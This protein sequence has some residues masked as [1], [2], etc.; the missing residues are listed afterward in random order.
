MLTFCRKGS[1]FEPSSSIFFTP[2]RGRRLGLGAVKTVGSG[3]KRR[4]AFSRRAAIS[5]QLQYYLGS[6]L[7]GI[8]MLLI[9]LELTPF[10]D[11]GTRRRVPTPIALHNW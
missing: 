11:S 8:D 2:E 6:L 4:R 5:T 10:Q 9:G 1:V 3:D 7:F